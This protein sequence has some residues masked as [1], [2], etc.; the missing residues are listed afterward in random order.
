VPPAVEKALV[1][2]LGFRG[3]ANPVELFDAI[4]ERAQVEPVAAGG[5]GGLRR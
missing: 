4:L 5:G 2:R 1:E 3:K